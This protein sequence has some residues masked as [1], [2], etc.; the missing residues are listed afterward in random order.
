ME[1]IEELSKPILEF[2]KEKYN[3]H[4]TVVINE[5]SIRVVSDEIHIP[6]RYD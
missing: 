5:D 6:I 1:E 2:L 3:P 4:T